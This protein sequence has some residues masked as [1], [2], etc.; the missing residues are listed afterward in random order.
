MTGTVAYLT[1]RFPR[2]SETFILDEI[3]GLE[4]AGVPLR[5]YAIADPHEKLVQPDVSRVKSPVVYLQSG[6][7]GP[8][9]W[10]AFR[11]TVVAHAQLLR[12]S[13]RRYLGVV[14]Y[15]ARRRRH[16]ST[17]KNFAQAG[18]LAVLLREHDTRHLHAAFAHGPAS[19]AHF[20]HLL[21]GLPYSFSAHAKDIYVSAP[22]LLARK[23]RDAS[24]VL[25]CSESARSALT[26]L[27]GADTTK[28]ILAHHGVDT[29]RFTSSAPVGSSGVDESPLRILAVGRLVAKK[30]YPV[31]LG[32]LKMMSEAG[33]T[34]RC[35]IVGEGTDRE[36][37]TALVNDLGLTTTVEFVGS[38]T[39]QEVAEHFHRADVFVQASVVLAN[40]DRDGIPNSLLEA[41]ASGLAVVASDVAGIPEVVTP[42]SGLLVPPG[43]SRALARAL[44]RLDDDVALR[45]RLG[46][47]A[48]EHVVEKFDRTAC[49]LRIA[50][51]F[52]VEVETRTD[53]L[54]QVTAPSV[55][56]LEG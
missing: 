32:A 27:S 51:L 47:Q 16:L 46:D 39:H 1:K 26:S 12:E 19:V 25:S 40:G 42:T 5:L 21:T 23:V 36:H 45:Q 34:P 44:E 54:G 35:T 18:R 20:V 49:A 8:E 10:R 4:A 37:L 9:R 22:D 6:A 31:L 17:V 33:R 53:A 3:L 7:M 48:R 56:D 24:F 50:P 28:V 41:M 55:A 15:I 52:G 14:S 2:L 11:E 30:G 38:Q 29:Q 13:P 43:D